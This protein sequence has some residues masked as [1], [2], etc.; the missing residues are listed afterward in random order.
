MK[1]IGYIRVSTNNQDLSRQCDKVKDF[2]KQNGYNLVRLIEDFGVSGKSNDRKGYKELINLTSNDCDLVVVSEISRL[3]RQE[4]VSYTLADI[5]TVVNNGMDLILLDNKTKI[6]EKSHPLPITDLI[7][8]IV[9]L[10][11]AAKERKEIL[12]KMQ[13][14]KISKYKANPYAVVDGRIP[15]GYRKIN[16]PEGNFPKYIIEEDSEEVAIIKKIFELVIKGK[17]LY[18]IMRYLIERNIKIRNILPNEAKLSKLVKNELYKGIRTR[19]VKNRDTEEII[20]Q[21]IKPIISEEDFDKAQEKV[22]SNYTTDVRETKY[23]NPLRGIIRCRC[24]RAMIVKD[25]KTEGLVKL[26]Y[27]CS[28]NEIRNSPNFCKAK[29]DEVSY[30]FTLQ[31]TK[32]LFEQKHIEIKEFLKNKGND[33]EV[34]LLEILSGIDGRIKENEQ[35]KISIQQEIDDNVERVLATTNATILQALNKKQDELDKQ[36]KNNENN[37][38]LLMQQKTKYQI[39]LSEVK[40]MYD[41]E[42]DERVKILKDEDLEE[43]YHKFLDKIEYHRITTMKG[44]YK[45]YFKSGQIIYVALSKVRCS[46]KA[47]VINADVNTETGDI[48]FKYQT[49]EK[50]ASLADFRIPETKEHTINIMDKGFF[51]SEWLEYAFATKLDIDLSFR[52]KFSEQIK[53]IGGYK[54]RDSRRKK[55]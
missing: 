15:F 54:D 35:Q 7:M 18:N 41:L 14:G 9:G 23:Y 12:T 32:S 20:V 31:V 19:K 28:C 52:E 33:K 25:K 30:D 48:K 27:R 8:L 45:Y 47:V 49:S 50:S 5:Q 4:D 3:S 11:G 1:V 21:R 55:W 24:G 29:I 40:S 2:C 53:A 44:F 43:V 37:L 39:Q 6:Y 36:M 26:V 38:E 13:D 51:T 17:T 42:L 10:W 22:K 46:P 34:E 16:N